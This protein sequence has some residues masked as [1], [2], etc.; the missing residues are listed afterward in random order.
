LETRAIEITEV[1]DFD[2]DVRSPVWG[3]RAR[4]LTLEKAWSITACGVFTATFCSRAR[5]SLF[6]KWPLAEFGRETRQEEG[7]LVLVLS[8]SGVRKQEDSHHEATSL[9]IV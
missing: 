5:C 7:V 8:G 3:Q 6:G 4:T 9:K 2:I 1:P